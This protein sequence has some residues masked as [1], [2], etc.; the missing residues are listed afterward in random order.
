MYLIT[1]ANNFESCFQIGQN[2]SREFLT[3][4]EFGFFLFLRLSELVAPF[5]RADLE[6]VARTGFRFG[7]RHCVQLVLKQK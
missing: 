2:C 3:S 7:N 1:L 6:F 5:A 4:T